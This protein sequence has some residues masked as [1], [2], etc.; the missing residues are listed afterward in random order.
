MSLADEL[1]KLAEMLKE[2]LL[3][4]SEFEQAKKGLLEKMAVNDINFTS[5]KPPKNQTKEATIVVVHTGYKPFISCR[6]SK[7]H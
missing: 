6:T 7:S 4:A 5:L 3:S 2:G 1:S